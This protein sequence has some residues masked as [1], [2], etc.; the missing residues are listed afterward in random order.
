MPCC[1]TRVSASETAEGT[2]IR[3]AVAMFACG[4]MLAGIGLVETWSDAVWRL[5]PPW[6]H[7]VPL[8][9]LCVL[10][11]RRRI[12]P[13]RC[14]GIGAVIFLAEGM[15]GGSIGSLLV[16][17]ELAYA[18]GRHGR[19]RV[20]ER[21]GAVIATSIVAAGLLA[22][23]LSR[24]LRVAVLMALTV[25]AVVGTSYWWG[26][27]AKKQADL[28]DVERARAA[29]LARM[30]DLR[31]EHARRS[32]RE[33]MAAELHDALSGS[34]AA[35]TIHS[36]AALQNPAL[37]PQALAVVRT[38][39]K[40]AMG[41][42]RSL[43]T[44]LRPHDGATAAPSR[45]E[46]AVSAGRARGLDIHFRPAPLGGDDL[47]RA[48]A[49]A[50]Y[51]VVQESLANVQRHSP[52]AWAHV[53]VEMGDELVITV[54]S[55]GI[56]DTCDTEG[57]GLTS[58]AERVQAL[59]GHLNAGPFDDGWRVVATIPLVTPLDEGTSQ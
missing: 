34:L 3:G 11:A 46:D 47:P 25:F 19:G 28:V 12:T 16:F 7:L 20:A 31:E 10:M 51:R 49:H 41:E 15:A 29:D 22:L 8:A 56:D 4:V 43:L 30:A 18:A 44:V 37:A 54:L 38:T 5:R 58:M 24:D 53:D 13:L 50:A 39:S 21:M 23:V 9:A 55:R 42:M 52:H 17:I 57:Y 36:E 59:G 48:V 35:I 2:D 1:N 40:Q 26:E 33:A 27:S 6:L 45:I 32:E 14:L